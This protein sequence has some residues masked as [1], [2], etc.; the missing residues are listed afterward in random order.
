MPDKAFGDS[1]HKIC[2]KCGLREARVIMDLI[3]SPTVILGG[4]FVGLFTALHL[5]QENY[6]GPVLL[7]DPN[8]RFTFKPR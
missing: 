7:I 6:P 8:D 2:E 1:D 5:G 4:G 3:S